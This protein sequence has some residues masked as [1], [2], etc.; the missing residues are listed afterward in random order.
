MR[1]SGA[2]RRDGAR[3]GRAF[4]SAPAQLDAAVRALT[5]FSW[6][7]ADSYTQA[8]AKISELVD[9]YRVGHT[10]AQATPAN[11]PPLPTTLSSFNS[12]PGLVVSSAHMVSN[13]TA[14]QWNAFHNGLSTT[15]F[16]YRATSTPTQ[17]FLSTGAAVFTNGLQSYTN[18]TLIHGDWFRAGVFSTPAD[19][20]GLTVGVPVVY[21]QKVGATSVAHKVTGKTETTAA[22]LAGSA[23]ANA[24][25]SLFS[26]PSLVNPLIG[27]W[28]DAL[29]FDYTLSA[30]Q[31]ATVEAYLFNR[32]GV[33]V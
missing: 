23:N 33:V 17:V 22:A 10:F 2:G 32:Y 7:R 25:M 12:K 18:G 24:P 4:T 8:G 31:E 30:P 20:T 28:V 27:E 14:A 5:P 26:N 13:L 3:N 15:Y 19:L 1:R 11:Q 9:R 16:V 6:P 29:F 21:R